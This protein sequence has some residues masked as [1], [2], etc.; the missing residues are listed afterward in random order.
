MCKYSFGSIELA[1]PIKDRMGTPFPPPL[2]RMGVPPPPG[3]GYAWTGC[4][5]GGMPLA[6]SRWRTFLLLFKLPMDR[7]RVPASL[8]GHW[9]SG[10]IMEWRWDTLGKGHWTSGR[11]MEIRYYGMD[12]CGNPP[13]LPPP[14]EQTTPV[15][16]VPCPSFESGW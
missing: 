3:T 8:K 1:T 15:K 7:D 2:D 10:S 12:V 4:A 6:V 9:A 11:F 16:T 14:F 13:P 5:V